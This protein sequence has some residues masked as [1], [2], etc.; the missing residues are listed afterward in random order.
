VGRSFRTPAHQHAGFVIYK[1]DLPSGPGTQ[2]FATG[3]DVVVLYTPGGPEG[4][5]DYQLSDHDRSDPLWIIAAAFA[6]AVVA[7]GRWRGLTVWGSNTRIWL[8][9][10]GVFVDQPA[11]DLS[12]GNSC[13]LETDHFRARV[14][15]TLMEG[16]V[17]AVPV[18]VPD[19]LGE[20]RPQVTFIKDQQAVGAL[21]AHG[22]HPALGI[23]IRDGR[24]ARSLYDSHPDGG[25]H[26]I[27]AP[28]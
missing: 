21:A 28:R 27:E 26:R 15:R 12:P 13:L 4:S 8:C 19:I 22:A 24:P 23:A 7:F 9:D 1:V 5:S 16:S 25:E 10:L 3:N 2:V 20:D 17:R 11:E 18:V 14:W 6:L